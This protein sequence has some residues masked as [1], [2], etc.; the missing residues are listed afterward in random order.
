MGKALKTLAILIL[1][2]VIA[3]PIYAKDAKAKIGYVDL[4]KV[5][6]KYH[7]TQKSGEGLEK[8]AISKNA[9]KDKL[10]AEIKKLSEEAELLSKKEKEKKQAEIEEK[11]KVL[12]DFDRAT[13]D[14]LNRERDS[15]GRDIL[16]EIGKGITEYG[17]KNGFD[18]ILDSRT[19]F[20]GSEVVDVTD[21][22]I[23]EMNK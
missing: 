7:K 6:D 23:K 21:E 1:A 4:Y 15:E 12:R 5:F 20:Y 18:M 13:R 2:L 22:I 9:E 17:E 19:L 3:A 8:K 14:E 16:L 10:I 11:A